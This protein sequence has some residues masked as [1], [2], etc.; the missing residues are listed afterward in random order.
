MT[1][2]LRRLHRWIIPA[3]LLVLMMAALLA[4]THPRPSARMDTLPPEIVDQ[5]ESSRT[6]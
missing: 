5:Q 3:L 1:R 6:R 2:P 4:L